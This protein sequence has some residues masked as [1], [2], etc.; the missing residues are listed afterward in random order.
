MTRTTPYFASLVLIGLLSIGTS[1]I[2]DTQDRGCTAVPNEDCDNSISISPSELPVVIQGILGCAND[3]VDKPYWDV[4]Y[5]FDCTETGEYKLGTCDSERDHYMRIWKNG[6]GWGDGESYL[7]DDD[8]CGGSP[9][10]ADPLI[11]AHF[12]A[13]TSYWIELGTWRDQMPWG[14]PNTPYT[15]TMEKLPDPDPCF[16]DFDFSGSVD[17]ADLLTIINAWGVCGGCVEDLNNDGVVSVSDLLALINN[18]G[19]CP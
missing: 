11:I 12:D 2:A 5:Q 10:S 4:F 7:E 1:T 18:W 17:V 13:G 14:A 15:F 9:P 8:S 6:C 19:S 3:E 16:G